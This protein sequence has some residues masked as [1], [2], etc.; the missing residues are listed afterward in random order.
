MAQPV[1]IGLDFDG[2]IIDHHQHKLRLAAEKGYDFEPWQ[3][4]TNVMKSLMEVPTYRGLQ[5]VL[6]N[7]LTLE[8]PPI[9]GAL[10][11]ITAIPAEF[12]IVCARA[13]INIRFAQEWIGQHRLYD[14]I[15]AERIFF[16]GTSEDK[17]SYCE[18]LGLQAFLDDKLGTLRVLPSRVQRFLFDDDGI[19]ESLN[20]ESDIDVVRN[21]HDFRHLIVGDV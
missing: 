8:A 10:E 2:V 11:T 3:T 16:C 1:R 20:V 7:R 13:P 15:P 9:A 19:A 18:R 21:W 4:N 5:D 17:R 14:L 6:Y 12:Y